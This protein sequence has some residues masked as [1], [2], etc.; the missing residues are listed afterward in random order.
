MSDD[1]LNFVSNQ[2][3]RVNAVGINALSIWVTYD[4]CSMYHQKIQCHIPRSLYC[5]VLPGILGNLLALMMVFHSLLLIFILQLDSS[6]TP[7]TEWPLSSLPFEEKYWYVKVLVPV[8]HRDTSI[9]FSPPQQRR[10]LTT[11]HVALSYLTYFIRFFPQKSN[12]SGIR[13]S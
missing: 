3:W 5:T 9:L 12:L 10:Q 2:S 11:T 13:E 6:A 8:G 4:T 7:K 1:V